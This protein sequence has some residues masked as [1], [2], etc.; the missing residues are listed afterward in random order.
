ML[1]NGFLAFFYGTVVVGLTQ[2]FTGFVGNGV[3]RYLLGIVVLVA[4][5][6]LQRG[7]NVG[8]CTIVI[9]IVFG[10]EGMPP[11]ALRR[12]F[13]RRA[14]DGTHRDDGD[15]YDG[16]CQVSDKD[17]LLFH[18]FRIPFHSFAMAKIMML[19]KMMVAP[20]GTLSM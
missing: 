17:I 1:V 15:E 14:P 19:T 7:I 9:G 12:I 4:C 16:V 11:S 20:D 18:F 10:V 5:F 13:L 2:F 8:Q 6:F 3:E